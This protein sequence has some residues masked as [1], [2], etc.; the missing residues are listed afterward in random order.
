M[1]KRRE[2]KKKNNFVRQYRIQIL[3]ALFVFVLTFRLFFALQVEEFSNDKAYFVLRQ[4]EHIT[5]TGTLI[6]DD[7]LGFSGRELITPP[8]YYY[9]LAF[10]NLFMPIGLV[11]KI[12]P[13]IFAS[14]IVFM[15]YLITQKFTRNTEASLFASALS[16]LLPIFILS[17]F[18]S[19]SIYS[20][21][22]PLVLYSF[23]SF[24]MISSN[25]RFIVPYIL[26]IAVLSFSHPS[27]LFVILGEILYLLL[28]KVENIHYK[29]IELEAIFTSIFLV[30]WSQF[31]LY[32]N[33]FLFHGFSI[34]WQNAPNQVMDVLFRRTNILEAIAMMGM[35][36][37]VAG[38]NI[39]FQSV[40]Q[41]KKSKFMMFFL[42]YSLPLFIFLWAKLINPTI[43]LIFLAAGL[44]LVTGKYYQDIVSYV[45]KTKFAFL[46][47]PIIIGIFLMT[48]ITTFAPTFAVIEDKIY[49]SPN[50]D[51]LETMKWIEQNTPEDSV[52]L[53]TFEDG[54]FIEYYANRKTVF[55]SDYMLIED[56]NQRFE[57][58][59]RFYETSYFIEGMKIIEKY[60]VDYILITKNTPE[61][62]DVLVPKMLNNGNCFKIKYTS[63]DEINILFEVDCSLEEADIE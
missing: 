10:F 12:I 59:Q 2:S 51:A 7:T 42:A 45:A 14:A 31:L 24:M 21:A 3:I 54:F 38:A 62:Y 50:A 9:I 34:I 53:A 52:V 13:N 40:H 55:D 48:F 33:A 8:V 57:E 41:G 27:V 17:T 43:G 60:D 39:F 26:S 18:N 35:I 6:S 15:V 1:F 47:V 4:V 36:P 46:K 30:V 49:A 16:G 32:K 28:L 63:D 23:Y 11:A 5:E 56:V 20:F 19:A 22:V 61:I 29:N 44:I 58:I 37:C 25:E